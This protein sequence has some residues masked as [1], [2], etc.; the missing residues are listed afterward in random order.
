MVLKNCLSSKKPLLNYGFQIEGQKLTVRGEPR[1]QP[2]TGVNIVRTCRLYR[3]LGM[4]YLMELTFLYTPIYRKDKNP[5]PSQCYYEA[6][7]YYDSEYP[8]Y[9]PLALRPNLKHLNLRLGPHEHSGEVLDTILKIKR[10]SAKTPNL[11]TLRVDI[12]GPS[13]YVS[14][15]FDNTL[16]EAWDKKVNKYTSKQ[17]PQPIAVSL[18]QVIITGLSANCAAM[19]VVRELALM[20]AAN[21]RL[22]LAIGDG[23]ERYM[24]DEG[25]EVEELPEP[26]LIW[27]DRKDVGTDCQAPGS[28]LHKVAP[29]MDPKEDFDVIDFRLFNPDI[30]F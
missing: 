5:R 15:D 10:W 19:M 27:L 9:H 17:P 29:V 18:N 26:S 24:L 12:I 3:R 4:K 2:E 28:W 7:N 11:S 8:T 25:S 16:F 20:L 30:H 14:E 22:G 6:K 21:G 1:A 13:K 23:G